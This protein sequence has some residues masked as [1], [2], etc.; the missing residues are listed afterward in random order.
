[1]DSFFDIFSVVKNSRYDRLSLA[2]VFEKLWDI[3]L[4]NRFCLKDLQ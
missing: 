1:M 4:V 2:M 3:L